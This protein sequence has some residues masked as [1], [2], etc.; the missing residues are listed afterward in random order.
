[1]FHLGKIIRNTPF[2]DRLVYSFCNSY[3]NTFNGFNSDIRINGEENILLTLGK[4]NQNKKFLFVDGGANVGSWTKTVLGYFPKYEG[5]L[6]ELMPATFQILQENLKGH[7]NLHI[8]NYGL[9][10]KS[11]T[12]YAKNFGAGHPCNTLVTELTN[13]RHE[14]EKQQVQCITLDEYCAGQKIEHIDLLKLDIEGYE[15]PALLGAKR[16]LE[17]KQ[18]DVIQFEYSASNL[19]RK[20][21]IRDFYNLLTPLGYIIGPMRPKGVR[22]VNYHTELNCSRSGP[23]YVAC[24]PQYKEILED[25]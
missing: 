3:V 22:F 21:I 23:N 16:L 2:L 13:N 5:H 12:M 17:N 4:I 14:E 6:F 1:M 15:F 10:D 20:E 9:T 8:N 18:I 7:D 19:E 24:L 25:K 11:Q